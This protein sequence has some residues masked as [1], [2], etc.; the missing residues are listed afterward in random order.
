MEEELYASSQACM[1]Q[2]NVCTT[3]TH[4]TLPCVTI[5]TTIVSCLSIILLVMTNLADHEDINA[6]KCIHNNNYYY[7]RVFVV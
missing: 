3:P 1:S 4:C 2:E 7:K 5:P 6:V